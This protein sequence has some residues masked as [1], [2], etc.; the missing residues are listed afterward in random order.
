[1]LAMR[2]YRQDTMRAM[3]CLWQLMKKVDPENKDM[4]N[5]GLNGMLRWCIRHITD[6]NP[7]LVQPNTRPEKRPPAFPLVK[8]PNLLG[9]DVP[10][11]DDG[12][13]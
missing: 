9:D 7:W 5:K 1:M 4:F 12:G 2:E 13:Y 8:G 11:Q 6:T 10:I 3:D